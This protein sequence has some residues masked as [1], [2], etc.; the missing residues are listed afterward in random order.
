MRIL[1]LSELIFINSRVVDIPELA[2]GKRKVR[3]IDLLEAAEQ[4]PLASAFGADAYPE[5]PDK[6]AALF[7]SLVRNHPFTDGNKRTATVAALFM[8]EVNGQ[9]LVW[10]ETEAL[11]LIVGTVETNTDVPELAAWFAAV[12]QPCD[13]TP[14]PDVDRDT[15]TID[16]L[17]HEHRWLLHELAS[18]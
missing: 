12:M 18:R 16:R 11:E 17:I 5:L 10:D 6:I 4:R 7:H 2:T 8:A 14:E 9:H 13:A 15:A 1:T 3:D